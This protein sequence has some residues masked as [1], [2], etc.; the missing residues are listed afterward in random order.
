MTSRFSRR[1]RGSSWAE[2][3]RYLFQLQL[4]QS[5]VKILLDAGAAHA[6]RQ[7]ADAGADF[8][9]RHRLA[10][11]GKAPLTQ[12]GHRRVPQIPEG[13]DGG[14]PQSGQGIG[15][16]HGLNDLRRGDGRAVF[17]LPQG[18]A[19]Q[20]AARRAAGLLQAEGLPQ[21]AVIGGRLVSRPVAGAGGQAVIGIGHEGLI[22]GKPGQGDEFPIRHGGGGAQS[23][24]MIGAGDSHDCLGSEALGDGVLD[25]TAHIRLPHKSFRPIVVLTGCQRAYLRAEG[26]GARV[27]GA[28][29]RGMLESP[30]PEGVVAILPGLLVQGAVNVQPPLLALLRALGI[31]QGQKHLGGQIHEPADRP[32]FRG[33]LN[34]LVFGGIDGEGI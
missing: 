23:L 2:R 24:H 15:E 3:A 11:G 8:G 27:I 34:G 28:G 20:I 21:Q 19:G 4:P 18:H 13:G 9:V 30:L 1:S 33:P 7:G 10:D 12:T 29:G 31:G 17:P 25:L 26:I 6:V 14:T 5:A 16:P 32:V 22:G